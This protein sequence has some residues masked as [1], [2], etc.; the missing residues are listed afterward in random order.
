MFIETGDWLLLRLLWLIIDRKFARR[1][2][3]KGVIVVVLFES[4][5]PWWK[6]FRGCGDIGIFWGRGGAGRGKCLRE[7]EFM[8]WFSL[9]VRYEFCWE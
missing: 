5:D 6:V 1:R 4:V 3:G 7:G 8:F 9:C 2:K